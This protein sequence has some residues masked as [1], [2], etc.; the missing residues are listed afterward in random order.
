MPSSKTQHLTIE[1]RHLRTG[2]TERRRSVV[3]SPDLSLS[4][5]PGEIVMLMGPNES[6]RSCTPWQACSHPLQA[7]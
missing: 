5:L 7:K 4:I 3:I 6:P 2:Y 1:L